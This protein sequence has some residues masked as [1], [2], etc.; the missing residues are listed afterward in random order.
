MERLIIVL[1]FCGLGGLT[2]L[3][4]AFSQVRTKRGLL[5]LLLPWGVLFCLGLLWVRFGVL[6]VDAILDMQ[7]Y[8][9]YA[10]FMW[11]RVL[12][13]NAVSALLFFALGRGARKLLRHL[14]YKA[15]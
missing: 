5:A 15:G 2:G 8:A 10:L 1:I 13:Y 12:I 11:P 7:Y 3:F 14:R 4:M 9:A 6:S